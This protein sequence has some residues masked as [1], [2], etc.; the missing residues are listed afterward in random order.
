M[1]EQGE[2]ECSNSKKG[3]QY[4]AQSD[5]PRK[6]IIAVGMIS[7]AALWMSL[8]VMTAKAAQG[9]GPCT[10]DMEKFC[11][12]VQPGGGNIARCLKEH[13]NDLSTACR[14]R[15][16]QVRR[17]VQEFREVCEDDVL[18]FC[19]DVK[20]GS[21]RIIKCLMEHERELSSGCKAK[22]ETRKGIYK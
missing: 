3:K 18:R 12:D 9:Q 20:P 5:V 10:S 11:K 4:M 7:T 17:Q 21:G 13:E 15:I 19:A 14:H 22:I 16:L 1:K 2:H 8:V 6:A